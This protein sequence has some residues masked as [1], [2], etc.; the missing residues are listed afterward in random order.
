MAKIRSGPDRQTT[1]LGVVS[2][3]MYTAPSAAAAVA[4]GDCTERAGRSEPRSSSRKVLLLSVITMTAWSLLMWLSRHEPPS[5]GT[6]VGQLTRSL[7]SALFL[8]AGAMRCT[9]W[10]LTR[11]SETLWNAMALI[12]IGLSLPMVTAV[13]LAVHGGPTDAATVFARLLM[14]F[15]VLGLTVVALVAGTTDSRLRPVRVVAPMLALFG[16]ATTM[17][18]I[19]GPPAGAPNALALPIFSGAE[20][21]A[22]A[23]WTG[24]AVT[25]LDLGRRHGRRLH[26]W[27]AASL[28]LMAATELAQALALSGSIRLVD[29]A[30]GLQMLTAAL[31]ACAAAVGVSEAFGAADTRTDRL[32]GDLEVVRADLLETERRELER[33]HDA[34]TALTG[35][36]GASRLLAGP[37]ADGTMDRDRLH[38]MMIA[39]LT[40][41]GVLLDPA[42]AIRIAPFRVSDALE[43]VIVAHRL[44]GLQVHVD[45]D[46]SWAMGDVGS[47]ATAAANLL[48]NAV[49]H[50]PGARVT[51]HVATVGPVAVIR[52]SDDGPGIP[53]AEMT[54]VTGAGTRGSTAGGIGSGLGLHT[55]TRAMKG[56]GGTLDLARDGQPGTT[57]LMTLPATTDPAAPRSA[58]L[59]SATSSLPQPIWPRQLAALT[60][61][62][63]V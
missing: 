37:T 19:I 46:A 1:E 6:A 17:A 42:A 5:F 22:T 59:H 55:A 45:V 41:V 10:R 62:V 61:P 30:T 15:A 53:V 2:L 25:L 21:L 11:T 23:V 4:A 29:F 36:M 44:A 43:P 38:D 32:T 20:W 3:T 12:V 35:L 13:R 56:Q 50:A 39:E 51:V 27:A 52:V 60:A 24:L 14:V 48:S 57:V 28:G 26:L 31:A 18:L 8:A 58:S 47:F 33:L 54:A 9:A 40:R 34:R 16:I 63:G 49:K 7:T